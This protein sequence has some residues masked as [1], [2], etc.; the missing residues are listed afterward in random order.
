MDLKL[1][2]SWAVCL[3]AATVARMVALWVAYG[4]EQLAEFLAV[5]S[6]VSKVH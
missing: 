5:L 1:A 6:A 2:F 4:V 3:A